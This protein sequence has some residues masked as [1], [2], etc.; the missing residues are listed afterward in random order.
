MN[1]RHGFQDLVV[2]RPPSSPPPPPS[3]Q[4][5]GPTAA[6]SGPPTGT[7]SALVP[8]VGLGPANQQHCYDD[9]T[10]KGS[11]GKLFFH[12]PLALCERIIC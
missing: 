8:V 11:R 6:H 7:F 12:E 5:A 1:C 10:G 3:T 2:L 9:K 4:G